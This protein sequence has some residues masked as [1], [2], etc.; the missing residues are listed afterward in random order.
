MLSRLIA[1]ALVAIGLPVLGAAAASAEDPSCPAGTSP[2]SSD[3]GVICV[4]V[5]DPGDPGGTGDHGDQGENASREQGCFESGGTKV[6]CVTSDG[7]WWSGS[8]CYA[9][10]YDAPPGSPAWQG[11]SDGSLWQCSRCEASG[12]AATCNV[13]IIW[14][15]P[16]AE[17]GPPR[18][19]ELASRAVGLMPLATADLRTAPQSPDPTYVGVDTW[20]WVPESQWS[21]LSKMVRAGPT[22]VTVTAAPTEIVWDMGPEP[23]TCYSPGKAWEQG[24]TDAAAT[25]CS[26]TY[27]R[28]SRSQP[29]GVFTIT[30]TIRYEVDWSCAGACPVTSGSIGL[31][32]APV[33]SGTIRV[34][35]R[36]TVV[37]R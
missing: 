31:V 33:G 17:P 1:I 15:P 20:M 6:P 21:T 8:Q 37:V 34:L 36:Q 29:G 9:A 12:G 22:S 16:G 27:D 4:V 10:P 18:P 24:M 7:N 19:G 3:Q 5:T 35:Q 13:E 32:D 28:T 25:S 14:T 11:Q 30:A 26:Y 2:V 23:V